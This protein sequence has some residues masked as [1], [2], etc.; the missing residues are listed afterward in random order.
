MDT[1]NDGAISLDEFTTF[2]INAKYKYLDTLP[3]SMQALPG[4]E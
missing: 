1:T 3:T 2:C 4:L